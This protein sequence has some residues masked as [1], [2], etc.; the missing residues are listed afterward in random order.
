MAI[1]NYATL[2]TAV[3]NWAAR[4]DTEFT[5]RIDDFIALAED[6][7]H[8][9]DEGQFRTDPLRILGM[10]TAADLTISAQSVAQ[11]TGWLESK[12]LY[13]NTDPLYDVEYMTPDR[14]WSSNAANSN[15]TGKPIIYTI[16]GTN[17]IFA[18]SPD[19]TYTGKLL[20]FKKMDALSSSLT[21]N[22]LIINSPGTYLYACILEYA[23]WAEDDGK[24]TKYAALFQGRINALIRQDSKARFSGSNLIVR[25]DNTP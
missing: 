2:V 13:I 18:Y 8:Y 16:E 10:E 24:I 11:P 23:L 17:F 6:R 19:S 21:T 15:T 22:W 14:F 3:T 12:R 9:G 5:N 4:S 1:N 25:T 20:F 7:I